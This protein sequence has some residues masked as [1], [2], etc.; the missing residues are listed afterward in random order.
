M[1]GRRL[2]A[3]SDVT[4]DMSVLT[5]A[6]RASR[7]P[8]VE[9]RFF[10][11]VM[12]AVQQVASMGMLPTVQSLRGVNPDLPAKQLGEL[13]ETER[14]KLACE[15][16][17]VRLSDTPGLEPEQVAALA[18]YLDSSTDATHAQR[19]R[20]AGV[21][22]AKWRGWMRNPVFA[23]YLQQAA[24]QAMFDAIP[25]AQQRVVEA[26]GRGERW[27]VELLMEMTGV[28]DRRGEGV[29]VR[30]LLERVFSVLD[31]ELDSAAFD[32]VAG[33]LKQAA[34]MQ[35]PIAAPA[36]VQEGSDGVLHHPGSGA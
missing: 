18:I 23:G 14:F 8:S 35:L 29:D 22:G 20:A 1:T 19:L 21:S 3:F 16:L 36:V 6:P 27:A 30:G 7:R 4:V 32:R 28:H 11:Q 2:D 9:E 24:G 25:L 26:A 13:M 31:E 17:G 33:R 15:E 5:K 10:A 12:F 34:G